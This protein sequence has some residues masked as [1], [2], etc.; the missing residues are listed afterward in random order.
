[1]ST[2]IRDLDDAAA[3]PA[4]NY[5]N[6]SYGIKSWLLTFDHKRIGLLYLATITV[7][8]VVGGVAATLM[9]MHLV[10]PQGALFEPETYNKMFSTHGI[11]MVFFFLVPSI[12][13][14][15]GNFLIP[16]MIGARD[17]AFP[18]LNLLSWYIFVTGCAFALYGTISGGVDTGWTF[19]PP[20]SSLYAQTHVVAVALGIF[21]AGFSSILTGLNFI[22]TIHK[23][24]APGMTWF[25][26]P[27]FIWAL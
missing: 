12:P 5:L 20:Y 27:L 3:E 2:A 19:Y 13:A 14:T 15:L 16:L 7:M 8:F 22:V 21:I 25:R 10:E 9:R 18:K 11:I 1:M 6:A 23:M 24:R 26:L 17:V 4:V